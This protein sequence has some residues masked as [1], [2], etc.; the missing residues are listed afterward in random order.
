MFR[1]YFALC[2][3]LVI[4]L[5]SCK[6]KAGDAPSE[7]NK[8]EQSKENRVS[9]P[10]SASATVGNNTVT[11]DYSSPR[12]KG[13]QIWDGLVK[14]DEVWRTGANEATT[15]SFSKDVNVEGQPL[16][17]GIYALFTIP[18][19]GDWTVIFNRIATQWGAFKYDQSEDALRVQVT[20]H[21]SEHFYENM[22][23]DIVANT[24]HNGGTVQLKWED[25]QVDFQFV[26]TAEN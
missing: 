5:S 8:Q 21:A 4:T 15:I 19:A 1:T 16:A 2:F 6:E 14:Y 3:A 25:L 26:N 7:K 17:A 22:T 10:A 20:P 24:T 9:P 13:R 18:T 11:V 23:F 12:V